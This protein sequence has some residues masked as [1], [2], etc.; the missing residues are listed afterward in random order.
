MNQV[1]SSKK[2]IQEIR[3]VGWDTLLEDVTLFCDKNEV[4]VMN[5]EDAYYNGISRRRGSQVS[6]IFY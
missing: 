3:D 6:I 2:T 4:E 5:M 1:S